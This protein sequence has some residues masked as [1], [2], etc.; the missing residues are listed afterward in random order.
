MVS[1]HIA[2]LTVLKGTGEWWW[3]GSLQQGCNWLK[4]RNVSPS[5]MVLIINDDT[6]FGPDFLNTAV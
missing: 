5:D 3:T 1:R 6:E 4:E 2:R